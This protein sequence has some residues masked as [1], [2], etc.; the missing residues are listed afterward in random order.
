MT[1]KAILDTEIVSE[2]FKDHDASVATRAAS[3]ARDHGVF[4]FTS[5]TGYEMVYGLELKG[6]SAD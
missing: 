6:S 5:V 4:T 2:Y 1:V 3:Y